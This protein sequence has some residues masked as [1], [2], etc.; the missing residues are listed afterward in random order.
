MF[1]LC[2]GL[3]FRSGFPFGLRFLVRFDEHIRPKRREYD[4]VLARAV[5]PLPRLLEWTKN[6]WFG[7]LILW[8]GPRFEEELDQAH[9]LLKQR[10]MDVVLDIAYSLPGDDAERRIVMIDW[11]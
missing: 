8:K 6:N 4:I 9:K 1:G 5:G 3:C 10:K 2:F 11:A 7:P